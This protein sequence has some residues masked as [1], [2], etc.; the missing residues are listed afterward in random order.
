MD[1]RASLND[2][3]LD[4]NDPPA[5]RAVERS[6]KARALRSASVSRVISRLLSFGCEPLFADYE[7]WNRAPRPEA[8]RPLVF[9]DATE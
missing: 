1:A 8:Q 5:F 9:G 6:S 3:G 7:E 4:G 2:V